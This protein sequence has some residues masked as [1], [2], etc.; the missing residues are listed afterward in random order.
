MSDVELYWNKIANSCG[1]N[2]NWNELHPTEQIRVIQS[3]NLL[4]SVV[5]ATKT[6][7]ST[8]E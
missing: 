3:I 8:Q 6:P 4:L 1:D 7:D 5:R 2:R